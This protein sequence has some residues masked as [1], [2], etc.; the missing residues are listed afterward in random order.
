MFDSTKVTRHR[1]KVLR[2]QNE[3][4]MEETEFEQKVREW[5]QHDAAVQ[6]LGKKA[7]NQGV[8]LDEL[9]SEKLLDHVVKSVGLRLHLIEMVSHRDVIDD[10]SDPMVRS[11]V[12][13]LIRESRKSIDRELEDD[14][15]EMDWD[16]ECEA[17]D[18]V[19]ALVGSPKEFF[20]NQRRVSAIV[21]LAEIPARIRELF[22]EAKTCYVTGQYNAVMALGRMMLE[23]AV[24]DI[25][26]RLGRFPEPDS[27]DDFYRD[28][29]PYERADRVLGT[30]SPQ[31]K[32][33][34]DLY[35]RGSQ[36]IHSSKDR[37]QSTGANFL[38]EVIAFVGE[39]YTVNFRQL[40][41][42]GNSEGGR[43]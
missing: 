40:R 1:V 21:A 16:T 19:Y 43:K 34:R 7:R 25:G 8:P 29:P 20:L 10:I 18:D 28:Y 9:D 13:R 14:P 2:S 38:E 11:G 22:E 37:D 24:T 36:A 3:L 33:F 5:M 35:R 27:V 42:N 6:D 12:V 15:L 26:I 17:W 31:R 32:R 4:F 39:I 23:Y 30:G 41:S